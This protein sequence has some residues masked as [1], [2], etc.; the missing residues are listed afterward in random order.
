[1]VSKDEMVKP[2]IKTEEQMKAYLDGYAEAVRYCGFLCRKNNIGVEKAKNV[3]KS[4][5]ERW[6][7]LQDFM[8]DHRA[9]ITLKEEDE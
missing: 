8:L 1:M 2:K 9:V 7:V 4:M 6:N 5:M 3:T